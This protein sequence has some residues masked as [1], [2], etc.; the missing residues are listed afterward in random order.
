MANL[1]RCRRGGG[2]AA[3]DGLQNGGVRPRESARGGTTSDEGRGGAEGSV[4]FAARDGDRLNAKRTRTRAP[5]TVINAYTR[6]LADF[7]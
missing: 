2:R 3:A 7:H 6:A 1:R 5:G 4:V